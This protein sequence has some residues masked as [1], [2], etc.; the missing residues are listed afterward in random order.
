MKQSAF[1]FFIAALSLIGS[2]VY[3]SANPSEALYVYIAERNYRTF[4]FNEIDSMTVSCIDTDGN[5]CDRFVTQEIWTPDTVFRIPLN[6]I[7]SIAFRPL[8]TIYKPGIIRLSPEF[9][10]HVVKIVDYDIYVDRTLPAALMPK[11]GDRL[12]STTYNEIFYHGM[13]GEVTD[14]IPQSD[15]TIIRCEEIALTDCYEQLCDSYTLEG[16]YE[17]D[18]DG[19]PKFKLREKSIFST[20]GTITF[21]PWELDLNELPDWMDGIIWEVPRDIETKI[22][23]TFGIELKPEKFK[24]NLTPSI[25][26]NASIS[27]RPPVSLIN[28]LPIVNLTGKVTFRSDFDFYLAS[29]LK[30]SVEAGP[31]VKVGPAKI[32]VEKEGYN[33]Y[34]EH[35]IFEMGL[36]VKHEGELML[37][38]DFHVPLEYTVRYDHSWAKPADYLPQPVELINI[39]NPGNNLATIIPSIAA[40]T[41]RNFKKDIEYAFGTARFGVYYLANFQC[42]STKNIGVS[43]G[44]S[45]GAWGEYSSPWTLNNNSIATKSTDL[46]NKLHQKPAIQGYFQGDVAYNIGLEKPDLKLLNTSFRKEYT[47]GKTD[48][49]PEFLDPLFNVSDD[50]VYSVQYGI[51]GT[52]INAH[53]VGVAIY[54][55][56]DDTHEIYYY[57]EPYRAN[58]FLQ[59]R[60][61]VPS[62]KVN[63][64][65]EAYPFVDQQ[66]TSGFWSGK[67]PVQILAEPKIDFSLEAV[68]VTLDGAVF[69]KDRFALKVNGRIDGFRYLRHNLHTAGI[70]LSTA[71]DVASAPVFHA[72]KVKEDGTFSCSLEDLKPSTRYYFCAYLKANDDEPVYGNILSFTTPASEEVDLGLSVNWCS[73]NLGAESSPDYGNYYAWGETSSGGN[74]SWSTY[75]DS[76]YDPTGSWVGCS[77]NSDIEGT[78]NDPCPGRWR[79]PTRSEME[80]LVNQCSWEWCTME[81]V[82]GYRVTGSSGAHIFLPAGGVA[83]GSSVNNTGTY[84]G[85]WGGTISPTTS[86]MAANLMFMGSSMHMV[87]WSN[88]YLGRLIRPVCPK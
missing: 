28:P 8:P 53:N 81:G 80:E 44:A 16:S 32:G 4:F 60:V 56:T 79:M 36:N 74:F 24:L 55:L 76:P 63:H 45:A 25:I 15:C 49:V 5:M 10:S 11:I 67:D 82:N 6:E 2:V 86:N 29:T 48:M 14:I 52:L 51:D 85:Y 69:N 70:A 57:M 37:A 35:L 64:K 40:K 54:D 13:R 22:P 66:T 30:A 7:D 43:I 41:I 78:E 73:H 46:Y 31:V 61:T 3:A 72:Q 26:Y 88:R 33:K 9:E 38:G 65:Y 18:P 39:L 17:P 20:D 19:K 50:D 87:Q 62:L 21:N 77:L 68:P 42:Y 34:G 59:Y 84:G 23:I 12:L 58:E 47:V 71:S 1:C 75:F 83:E 27:I